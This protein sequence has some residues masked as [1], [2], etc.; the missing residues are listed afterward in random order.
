MLVPRL[1]ER[2]DAVHETDDI[3]IE[4]LQTAVPHTYHIDRP[5]LLRLI[6][7]LVEH[8]DD[9]LLVRQGDI[10]SEQ[11]GIGL[12]DAGK[13]VGRGYLKV[14]ILGINVLA[15]EFLGK[16]S[17]TETVSQRVANDSIFVHNLSPYVLFS[18]FFYNRLP[19]LCPPQ[20]VSKVRAEQLPYHLVARYMV[21]IPPQKRFHCTLE[22]PFL[23]SI[24]SISSAC[25]NA[26]MLMGR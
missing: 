9:S 11:V 23:W 1:Q 2:S 13:H 20:Q 10:E 25:G 24:C 12:H 18:L 17:T 15:L 6:T 8:G 22:K 3:A 14:D 4:T 26:S 5:Y 7:Q 21:L 16:E 19:F